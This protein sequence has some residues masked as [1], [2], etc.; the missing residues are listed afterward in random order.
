MEE[1]NNFAIFGR[2]DEI[3]IIQLMTLQ[4]EI[5]EL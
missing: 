5:V 3:N 2:F 4:A 1:D